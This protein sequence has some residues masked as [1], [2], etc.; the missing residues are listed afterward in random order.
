MKSITLLIT[1][2]FSASSFATSY[3]HDEA[4]FATFDTMEAV[5]LCS[6]DLKLSKFKKLNRRLASTS[7]NPLYAKRVVSAMK[8][9]AKFFYS[10]SYKIEDKSVRN[11][12]RAVSKREYQELKKEVMEAMIMCQ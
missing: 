1:L 2:T 3:C 7:F 10:D 8:G 6:K 4:Q 11:C 5:E 9:L 12:L